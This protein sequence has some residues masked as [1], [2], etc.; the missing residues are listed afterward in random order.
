MPTRKPPPSTPPPEIVLDEAG[1][2]KRRKRKNVDA[3]KKGRRALRV[4][5]NFG[6]ASGQGLTIPVSR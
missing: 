1:R 4:D 3:N 2:R 6:Q 5:L